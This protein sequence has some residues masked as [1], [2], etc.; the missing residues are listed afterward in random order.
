[1]RSRH[2]DL[3]EELGLGLELG[4]RRHAFGLVE[5]LQQVVE[6]HGLE[7]Q[8]PVP[9]RRQE[10]RHH[11]GGGDPPADGVLAQALEPGEQPPVARDEQGHGHLWGDVLHCAKARARARRAQAQAEVSEQTT[12]DAPNINTH[13][14]TNE[15]QCMTPCFQFGT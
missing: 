4:E 10:G 14:F 15:A 6:A 13:V 9:V 12:R 5:V 2:D 11:V 7:P 1:M 8:G 3:H